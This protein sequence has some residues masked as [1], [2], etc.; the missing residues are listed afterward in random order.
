MAMT[1]PWRSVRTSSAYGRAHERT[2]SCT[3]GSKPEGLGVWRRFLRKDR[4]SS[5]MNGLYSSEARGSVALKKT[6]QRGWH[7]PVYFTLILGC[8]ECGD[9]RM[10]KMTG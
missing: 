5:C 4:E 10:I 8:V 6:G 1:L 2:T 3:G 9:D 7:H